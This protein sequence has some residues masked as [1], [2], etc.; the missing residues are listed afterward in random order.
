MHVRGDKCVECVSSK[1][2]HFPT[3]GIVVLCIRLTAMCLL[4]ICVGIEINVYIGHESGEESI[5]AERLLSLINNYLFFS[6]V[7]TV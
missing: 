3:V 7:F 2:E 4:F 1:F 6:S 5:E